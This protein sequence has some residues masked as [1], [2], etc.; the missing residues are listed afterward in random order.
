M[1][2]WI[3]TASMLILAT[4][5]GCATTSQEPAAGPLSAALEDGQ[6]VVRIDGT[7][8]TAYKFSHEQK[9]PYFWPVNGPA[10]GTSVTVES[11]QPYPHHHSL[12]FGCDKVNGGNYWQ[13]VNARGQILSEGPKLVKAT[14]DEIVFTD[15]CLWKRPLADPVIRDTR[16]VRITAPGDGVRLIDFKIT[17]TPLE[18]VR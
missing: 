12:F 17:L 5:C 14:G 1:T 13:D 6:L 8:F 2:D 4:V 11:T 15:E 3:R 7:I 10:S 16:R 9:Y 18:D